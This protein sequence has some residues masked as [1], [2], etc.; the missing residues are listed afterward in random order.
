MAQFRHPNSATPIPP[1][2]FRHPTPANSGPPT[3]NLPRM[4][5]NLLRCIRKKLD[6]GPIGCISDATIYLGEPHMR[7]FVIVLRGRIAE[8]G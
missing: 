4:S 6:S 7:N 5:K 2:Q 1:P 3:S 8:G